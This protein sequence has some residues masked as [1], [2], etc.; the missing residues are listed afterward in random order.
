MKKWVVVGSKN[1]LPTLH[2][3]LMRMVGNKLNLPTLHKLCYA[4]VQYT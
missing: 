3:R 2:F 1:T 4:H